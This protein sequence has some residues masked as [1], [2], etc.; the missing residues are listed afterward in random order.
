M[1]E[2]QGNLVTVTNAG[3]IDFSSS[4]RAVAI[5]PLV[6]QVIIQPD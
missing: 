6:T 2:C 3:Q 5:G 4:A 1:I